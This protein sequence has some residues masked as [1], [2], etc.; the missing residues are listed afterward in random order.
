MLAAGK[1][2][3]STPAWVPEDAV[4]PWSALLRQHPDLLVDCQLADTQVWGNWANS[5]APEASFPPAAGLKLTAFQRLLLVQVSKEPSQ[6]C[7]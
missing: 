7:P 5:P 1:T 6:I 3:S 2:Q 4:V